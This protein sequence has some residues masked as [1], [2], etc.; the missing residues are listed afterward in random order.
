MGIRS[1]R[2][3]GTCKVNGLV[4]FESALKKADCFGVSLTACLNR[5]AHDFYVIGGAMS[6]GRPE[7]E[8]QRVWPMAHRVELGL[9]DVPLYRQLYMPQSRF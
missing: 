4:G 6:L 9:S 8:A 3:D 7:A 1:I 5:L 2:I